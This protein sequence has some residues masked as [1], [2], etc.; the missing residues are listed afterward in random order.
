LEPAVVRG[1]SYEYTLSLVNN[2][3]RTAKD[4]SVYA[5]VPDSVVLSGFSLTPE[6]QKADTVFWK[7]DS[8]IAGQSLT[9]TYQALLTPTLPFV[10]FPLPAIAMASAANDTLLANNSDSV[11][12]YGIDRYK[13]P[14][15]KAYDITVNMISLTDTSII[16]DDKLFS[17]ARPGEDYIYQ[18]SIANL[19]GGRADTAVVTQI[20]PDSV[21]YT[22]ASLPFLTREQ[23]TIRWQLL[24][25]DAG[26]TRTIQ[27]D[28]SLPQ[29]LPLDIDPRI[30]AVTVDAKNDSVFENNSA[31]DTVMVLFPAPPAPQPFIEAMPVEIQVRDAIEIRVMVDVEIF[32]WDLFVYFADGSTDSTYADDFIATNALL[33]GEWFDVEPLFTDTEFKT[34]SKTE[35]IRFEIRVIDFYGQHASAET[36]VTIKSFNDMVLDRNQFRPGLG[37][38]LIINFRL[39]SNRVAQLDVYDVAGRHITKLSEEFYPAGW[40]VFSWNGLTR[41]GLMVGSG[42]YI[43]TIR[44][45]EYKDWKKFMIVR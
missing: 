3:P 11:T 17:A 28:V 7:T 29:Q 8:L 42:V 26:E 32:Q 1:D 31:A 40:N 38:P 15:P 23:Q 45:G 9:I 18:I 43:I 20:L 6:A 19:G 44:S 2:G 30:S 13:T 16:V 21:I 12:V 10:P 5:T 25:L 33:P 27:V 41:T 14:R 35:Q 22:G 39:S 37:D 36:A 4:I 24:N 34:L